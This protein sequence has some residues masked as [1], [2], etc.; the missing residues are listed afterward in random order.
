M[1]TKFLTLDDLKTVPQGKK[2][3]VTHIAMLA[4]AAGDNYVYV[5]RGGLTHYVAYCL[6]DTTNKMTIES[7]TGKCDIWLNPGDEV[8]GQGAPYNVIGYEE[9]QYNG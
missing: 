3:H 8:G 1:L 7:G 9:I 2:W 4:L 5:K 6:Y